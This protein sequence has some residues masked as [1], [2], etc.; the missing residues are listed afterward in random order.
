MAGSPRHLPA[1]H[2][3][4]L[5]GGAGAGGAPIWLGV[6][7]R[8]WGRLVAVGATRGGSLASHP[9]ISRP[10][11]RAWCEGWRRLRML[12]GRHWSQALR[13]PNPAPLGAVFLSSVLLCAEVVLRGLEL[14]PAQYPRPTGLGCGRIG[15]IPVPLRPGG[16]STALLCAHGVAPTTAVAPRAELALSLT[17]QA[18]PP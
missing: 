6:F 5:R 2:G 18:P 15:P 9:D 16:Q 17:T 13:H 1:F 12:L 11:S 7:S 8:R 10:P 4:P 3:V 14:R